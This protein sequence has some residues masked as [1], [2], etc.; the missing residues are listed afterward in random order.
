MGDCVLIFPE[1]TRTEG[2]DVSAFKA[3]LGTLARQAEVSILPVRIEGTDQILPKGK[4]LP[5]GRKA[6]IHIGPPIP[7]RVLRERTADLGQLAQDRAIAALVQE[8]VEG[9]PQGRYWWL[10]GWR[11]RNVPASIE[12]EVVH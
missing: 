9:L 7:W 5:R 10:E 4:A 8:A 3:S 6:T 12:A 1:G 2:P 11:E